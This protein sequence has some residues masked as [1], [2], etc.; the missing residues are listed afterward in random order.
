[1][2]TVFHFAATLAPF[3]D[4]GK[5]EGLVS[6]G[7]LTMRALKTGVYAPRVH[8]MKGVVHEQHIRSYFKRDADNMQNNTSIKEN[9]SSVENQDLAEDLQEDSVT[10]EPS[11][12]RHYLCHNRRPSKR[13]GRFV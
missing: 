10:T 11:S 1:M 5:K 7:W 9:D 3:N 12:S 6:T 13:F 8:W 4:K 2:L